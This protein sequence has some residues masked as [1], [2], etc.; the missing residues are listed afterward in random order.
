M[1]YVRLIAIVGALLTV[2]CAAASAPEA[3]SQAL[4][5]ETPTVERFVFPP[6]GS[7][8]SVSERKKGS[9]GTG[10]SQRTFR[11]LGEQTWNGRR[12]QA[13]TDGQV[14]AYLDEAGVLLAVVRADSEALVETY[15]P[16]YQT[17]QWPLAV[18]KKWTTTFRFLDHATNRSFEDVR[19]SAAV[20]RYEEVETPAGRFKAFKIVHENPHIRN[21]TW[22]SPEP[23]V[24]VKA[25]RERQAS[26]YLGPGTHERELV[27]YEIKR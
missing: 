19:F 23:G 18:G 25:R 17:F 27:S 2:G 21:T 12:V 8:W 20:E 11:A 6:A 5:K 26:F 3:G 14:K 13:S 4:A 22:W 15:E 7:T 9:F 1:H 16:G 10:T 24:I